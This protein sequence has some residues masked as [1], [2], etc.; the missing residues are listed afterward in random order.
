[1]KKKVVNI[2]KNSADFIN[3]DNIHEKEHDKNLWN[4]RLKRDR[5]AQSIP[6]WE[7]LKVL[8]SKIKEHSLSHLDEY[9]SEFAENATKRGAI[10][11]W[12]RDAQEH[13]EI[14]YNILQE[15]K[16]TEII[17]SK[18]MLQE[19][20]GM[21]SFLESKGIEVTESDLG[22]RI[23]QLSHEPPAHIV[24]PAIEK[25]TED[26]AKL[27]A[28]TIGTDPNDTDAHSLN[29][30]MRNNAR[31]KFLRAGAGMTGANF[32]IAET[33]TFVVCT[34][35]GNADIGASV[36]PLHIASIGIE[37]I[38]PKVEDLGIFIRL[39]SRSALGTP[40]TQYTS[41]FSGPRKNG[42]L[43]I[44][45]T[46]NGRSERLG[47]EDFWTSLKCIRCGACM[48][49]CPVYRRSGGLS[50]ESTYSGPIGIIL[51]P[52]FDLEKYKELP[53]H[54]T[55]CGSCSD[56]C[57]V[58]ID[59]SGQIYKWRKMVVDNGYMPSNRKYALKA[60]G[61]VFGHPRL[62]RTT[63]AAAEKVLP[64]VPDFLLYSNINPWTQEREM[65]SMAK[66]TFREWYIKNRKEKND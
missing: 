28:K 55:L 37:K 29:E 7:E 8:A 17:K 20:C 40:A 50:Y 3:Q 22:E 48:N 49:T 42:E 65:F 14:V 54:S 32:A 45:I 1:M 36:P 16:V 34:N 46:D 13:N 5:I 53:Y 19:E 52:T 47:M 51:S 23:Q 43:H 44:I 60:A 66:N 2:E 21:T 39:L 30:A 27:F 6:E 25:T 63:E 10:V 24:M 12:A 41:H 26:I 61:T 18:S 35:E 15:R 58:K 31:P 38:I 59:I 4:A 57:P 56:V 11:H 62:F 64:V 9:V 33:G